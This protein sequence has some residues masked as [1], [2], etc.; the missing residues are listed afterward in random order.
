M[1]AATVLLYKKRG[2][3][4]FCADVEKERGRGGVRVKKGERECVCVYVRYGNPH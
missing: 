3:W 2:E 1:E 4:V